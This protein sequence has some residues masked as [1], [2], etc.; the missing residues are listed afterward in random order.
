MGL[1]ELRANAEYG[2]I[3]TKEFAD[4]FLGHK[5]AFTHS[6]EGTI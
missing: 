5:E 1:R 2:T 4:S 6:F 3:P